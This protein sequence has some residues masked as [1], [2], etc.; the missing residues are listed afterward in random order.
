MKQNWK[1]LLN[2]IIGNSM[3]AF[4][5]C[6]FVV[7]NNIMMGGSTGIALTI[8]H[9][10]P[11]E[12]RLSIISACVNGILFFM[13]L[14]FLGRKFAMA[15]LASTVLFPVIMGVM[16]EFPI[17]D[18][19]HEDLVIYALCCG[20]LFGGGI[21]LVVRVGGSTG[22]MDIP[23]C[24]L[25]KYKGIPVGSSLLFFDT[26]IL[27]MQVAF[28]GLDG[29][30]LSIVITIIASATVN[31]FTISGERKVE[32]IIISSQSDQIKSAILNTEDCGLTLLKVET[33]YDGLPQKAILSVVYASKCKAIRD[34]ALR[35]D[36]QAFIVVNE[37]KEVN[38]RGYTMDRF[39][40]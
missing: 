4:A 2:L 36:S 34:T 17:G 28:R 35:I 19:F 26:S 11:F 30:L 33:G 18:L 10:L 14:V 8:Q 3:I 40:A 38:G 13:G 6:A 12:V 25:H 31:Y 37:V 16:E 5:V 21:G 39:Q 15:S 1:T 29:I 22:G 27:L 7:P 23:P 20:L 9:F 24:I 32:I